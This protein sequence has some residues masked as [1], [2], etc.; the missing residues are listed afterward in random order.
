MMAFTLSTA[1]VAFSFSA[2]FVS[3]SLYPKVSSTSGLKFEIGNNTKYFAGTNAY[4]LP[5]T[6]NPDDID[7]ALD[8]IADGGLKVVRTWG[9][10]DVNEIPKNGI[11]CH[12]DGYE[13][14]AHTT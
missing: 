3:A 2:S 6:V 14:L 4:W 11:F 1:F 7:V 13:M 8:H 5:F 9:F 10:N 12:L